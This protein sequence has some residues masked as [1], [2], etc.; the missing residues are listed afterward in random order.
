MTLLG[1]LRPQFTVFASR[2]FLLKSATVSVIATLIIFSIIFAAIYWR[3]KR[4]KRIKLT[5]VEFVAGMLFLL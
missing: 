5:K 2:V 4:A 3:K 1:R